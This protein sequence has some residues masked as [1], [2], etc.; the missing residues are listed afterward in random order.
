MEPARVEN[1]QLGMVKRVCCALAF[2]E[3]I[4]EVVHQRRSHSV[5]LV[6]Y[7]RNNLMR[8]R[9]HECPLQSKQAFKRLQLGSYSFASRDGH[10]FRVQPH[11]AIDNVPGQKLKISALADETE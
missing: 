7:G 10:K 3:L 2:G 8:S 4:V 1:A 5:I 9:A 11:F 6:P